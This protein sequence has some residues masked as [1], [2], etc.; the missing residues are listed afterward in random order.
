MLVE[1][2]DVL[3]AEE[4]ARAHAALS[5]APWID[6]RATAGHQSAGV[7]HNRQIEEGTRLHPEL[8]GL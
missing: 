6:G 4:A 2:A 3:T 5:A 7:K 8:G 1:I